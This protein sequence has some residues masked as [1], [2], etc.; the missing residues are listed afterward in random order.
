MYGLLCL[1]SFTGW[2]IFHFMDICHT[3]FI[4]LAVDGRLSCFSS[5]AVTGNV[6]VS[7]RAHVFV[8]TLKFSFRD[9]GY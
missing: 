2:I 6:A 5:L 8:C 9:T 1:A 7:I 4:H 3:L